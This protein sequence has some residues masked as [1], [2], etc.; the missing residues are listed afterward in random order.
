MTLH[1]AFP[2]GAEALVP[3][4]LPEA[5]EAACWKSH[6][7]FRG[8][9]EEERTLVTRYFTAETLV[10]G[11]V[12]RP[13][14]RNQGHVGIVLTGALREDANR[15]QCETDLLG[16]VFGGGLLCPT[17]PRLP[18]LTETALCD[19]Q[20]WI[21]PQDDFALLAD[22][23]PRLVTNL[24][25][26]TQNRLS[27]AIALYQ[28]RGSQTAL[29]RVAGLIAHFAAR[30]GQPE[31]VALH[32]SRQDLGAL[33]ALTPETVSRKIKAL[34]RADILSLVA[35]SRLVIRDSRRLLAATWANGPRA[36]AA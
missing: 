16:V 21:C 34:E 14:D 5:P 36:R 6:A 12:L 27:E 18:Q 24:V 22:Q 25:T 32:L 29:A 7:L 9:T 8:L 20:V 3:P 11:E 19:T 31:V 35:P 15:S 17:G 10:A 2:W 33:A 23:I 26:E 1:T 13:I 4:P 30:Q 28:L